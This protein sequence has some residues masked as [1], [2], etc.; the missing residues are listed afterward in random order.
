MIK[1]QT[2]HPFTE[3]LKINKSCINN[4]LCIGLDPDPQK[5]S[6][7]YDQTIDGIF[8]FLMDI[9]E[10]SLDQ[11]I[12]YKPNISF[13]EAL[14]ISGLSMLKKLI[15]AIPKTHPVII[16]AKRGDI[17]NT[18]KM[19][20]QFLFDILGAD[21]TTLHPYMGEDSIAPFLEYKDKFHFILGLTSN[22]GAL[23]FEKLKIEKEFLYDKVIYQCSIWNN[24]YHNVGVVAGAT[25]D[26]LTQIRAIDPALLFLIP[27]VGEQGGVY[28]D[29]VDT[30]V[31]TDGLSV[32]NTSRSI[33]YGSDEKITKAILTQRIN[34]VTGHV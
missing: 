27:G 12:C 5:M 15:K 21:A 10:S 17:G 26:E 32:I 2:T 34:K 11:C 19:Q 25:Q 16:D 23:V 8:S 24:T 31:N 33:L 6:R 30:G 13:F 28:S 7:Y 14:D 18:S 22:P 1:T 20:A 4:L 3:Q 9:V 29:I